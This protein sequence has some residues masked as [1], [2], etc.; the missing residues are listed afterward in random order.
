MSVL[1][2]AG[3]AGQDFKKERPLQSPEKGGPSNKA[4]GGSA[5]HCTGCMSRVLVLSKAGRRT[6]CAL[7]GGSRTLGSSGHGWK[8][9]AGP[10]TAR[11][12]GR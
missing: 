7:E 8:H 9:G 5:T 10:V 11:V 12:Y 3:V 4:A 6:T 1:V 2:R